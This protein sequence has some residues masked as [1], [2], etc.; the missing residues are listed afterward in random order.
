M[1][2]EPLHAV[3]HL[4]LP[5]L[6]GKSASERLAHV[7]PVVARL[8][9]DTII[10]SDRYG[11]HIL[12][13]CLPSMYTSSAGRAR[14]ERLFDELARDA[15]WTGTDAFPNMHGLANVRLRKRSSL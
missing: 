14:E 1:P 11:R 5:D 6:F 10:E 12:R 4:G 2:G 8:V 3:R 7:D 9:E 15:E 13:V